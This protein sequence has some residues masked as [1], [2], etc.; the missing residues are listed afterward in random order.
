[1]KNA[2]IWKLL[3]NS[4]NFKVKK[5]NHLD[6]PYNLMKETY[7]LSQIFPTQMKR[8][9][10]KTEKGKIG[11]DGIVEFKACSRDIL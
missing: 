5:L 11:A 1:M 7:F 3:R 8:N 9:P 4:N 6:I 2:Q 10:Q